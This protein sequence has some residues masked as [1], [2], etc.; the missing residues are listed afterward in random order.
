MIIRKITPIIVTMPG[1]I[2]AWVR[3]ETDYGIS[4][5]GEFTGNPITNNAVA[6]IINTYAEMLIHKDPLNIEECFSSLTN[7]HYPSMLDSRMIMMAYSAMNMALWDIKAK[8]EGVPLYKMFSNECFSKVKLYG[9]IKHLLENDYSGDT[10]VETSVAAIEAGFH[11]IKV[12]PFNEVVP[13]AG[14]PDIEPGVQRYKSLVSNI[15]IKKV[16]LDCNCRF[17]EKSFGLLLNQLKFYTLYIPFIEDPIRIHR[18]ADIKPLYEA[19]PEIVYSTGEDCFSSDELEDL[20]ESKC[21]RIINPDIKYI[22]GIC[23]AMKVIPKLLEKGISIS[24][25]CPSGPVAAAH[26]AHVAS[27]CGNHT[28]MEFPF[29]NSKT[30][31]QA[32]GGQEPVEKGSYYVKDSPGIGIEPTRDFLEKYGSK[33]SWNLN[34]S[35][36]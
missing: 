13:G 20:A 21:I 3:V 6:A 25:H 27:V 24:F 16:A 2:W 35:C 8:S 29:G 36:V 34:R 33:V 10:L 18:A 9:S 22:G 1:D 4:G 28:I 17:N 15:D 12:M 23:G 14:G 32:T 11:L 31:D 5:W 19:Y 26:S 7:W 30:R